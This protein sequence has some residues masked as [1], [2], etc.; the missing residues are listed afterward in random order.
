MLQLIEFYSK[1]CRTCDYYGDR[2]SY[3]RYFFIQDCSKSLCQA[4]IERG[5]RRFGEYFFT[6]MCA[7]C[8][9]CISIRQRVGDFVLSKSHRRVIAKNVQT[10]ITIARPSIS[11]EKLW[12]YDKY[13]QVME[14][15]KGWNYQEMSADSYRES[16]VDGYGDFGYEISYK[17]DGKLAGVGYFDLL[18]HGI[19][20]A[21]FFYDHKF[22][23][24]SLGTFNILT[25][26]LIAKS[27]NL[28]YFY[29]GYWIKDHHSVGYKERFTPFEVLVN[30]PEIFDLPIW[31]H[32]AKPQGIVGQDR[33]S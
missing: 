25:Q 30:T 29:P 21:Y 6:P 12:L 4:L 3:F 10:S 15:K 28:P 14:G 31:E 11:D 7:G 13:H 27:K 16:F 5:F 32:Y 19:S 33:K 9:E 22:S 2:Y 1:P 18:H 8:S 20:A 17:I 26:L 24:L 23:K